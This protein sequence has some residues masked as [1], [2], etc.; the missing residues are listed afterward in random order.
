MTAAPSVPP[1]TA[2]GT[3]FSGFSTTSALAQAVPVKKYYNVMA[4]E[5]PTALRTE[6]GAER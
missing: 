3:F 6:H 4:M 5:E 2:I 1:S